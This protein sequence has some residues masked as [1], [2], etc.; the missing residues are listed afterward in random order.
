MP[1]QKGNQLGRKFKPGESGN[2]LG[3]PKGES[4]VA[5]LR[6]VLAERDP[7][8]GLTNGEMIVRALIKRARRGNIEAFRAI[9]DRVEGRPGPQGNRHRYFTWR[10]DSEAR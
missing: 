10:G 5:I 2:P 1:F 6:Q 9:A 7:R 3:R 4:L 8:T